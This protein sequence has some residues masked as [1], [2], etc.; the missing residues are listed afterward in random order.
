MG[1]GS[2]RIIHEYRS[3]AA[4]TEGHRGF[5]QVKPTQAYLRSVEE[6]ER[7]NPRWARGSAAQ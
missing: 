7:E 1:H 6:A 2:P 3:E 4:E 5:S